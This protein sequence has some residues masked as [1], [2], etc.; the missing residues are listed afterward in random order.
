MTALEFKQAREHLGMSV[1]DL[2]DAFDCHARTI[3]RIEDG[4]G[5]TQITEYAIKYLAARKFGL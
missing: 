3:M 2:A 1:R 5:P 4:E